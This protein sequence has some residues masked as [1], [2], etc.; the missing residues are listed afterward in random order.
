MSVAHVVPSNS[1]HE[2]R[3]AQNR[4][5]WGVGQL[6]ER[7]AGCQCKKGKNTAT[8]TMLARESR[9]EKQELPMHEPKRDDE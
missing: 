1:I 9:E 6:L 8:R 7:T 4:V 5:M 2:Q 3:N